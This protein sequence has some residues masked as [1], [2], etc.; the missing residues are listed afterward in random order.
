LS[1]TEEGSWQSVPGFIKMSATKKQE[2]KV[3]AVEAE[4]KN[5]GAF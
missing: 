2:V 4:Y 1:S 3:A 5:E